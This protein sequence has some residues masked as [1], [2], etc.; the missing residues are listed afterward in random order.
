MALLWLPSGAEWLPILL[1]VLLLFGAT[2]VPQLMRG[3]GEGV[4]EFKKAINNDDE[5]AQPA[6]GTEKENTETKV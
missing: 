6:T 3:L 5:K 4:R 1:V 2:K